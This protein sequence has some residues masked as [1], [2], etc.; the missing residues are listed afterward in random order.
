MPFATHLLQDTAPVKLAVPA[1]HLRN[2]GH[3]FLMELLREA[4]HDIYLAY[5]TGLFKFSTLQDHVD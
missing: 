1:V 2:L 5:L 4:S 3:Q